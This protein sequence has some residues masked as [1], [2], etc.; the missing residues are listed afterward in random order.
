MS[1]RVPPSI[2]VQIAGAPRLV[3]K[4]RRE[5][6]NTPHECWI[7]E[8]TGFVSAVDRVG[9]RSLSDGERRH[10]VPVARRRRVSARG[11]RLA[12]LGND[13]NHDPVGE[14]PKMRPWDL[15]RGRA[16]RSSLR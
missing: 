8:L 12:A 5:G 7:D 15:P 9:N 16:F 4:S 1:W 14:A 6:P 11:A 2:D 10:A 13:Q 3:D